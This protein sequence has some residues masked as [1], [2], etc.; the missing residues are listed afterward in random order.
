MKPSYIFGLLRIALGSIFAWAFFDKL[1]GLNFSTPP[2]KSWLEGN[3]PTLGYLKMGVKGPFADI[4]HALAGNAIVDWL[5]MIGLIGIGLALVFGIAMRLATITGVMLL[6][7][8]FLS[9][10][11]PEHHPFMD[12]HIIYLL[13][14]IALYKEKAG[15]VLG[16]ENWWRAQKITTKLPFLK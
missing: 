12:E 14:L 3:S 4:F 1:F 9:F 8:L 2:A 11:P 10:L 7:F 13:T 15:R 16:L 6:I 5:F